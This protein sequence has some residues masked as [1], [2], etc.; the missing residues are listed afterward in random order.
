MSV[1][2]YSC[3]SDQNLKICNYIKP[4]SNAAVRFLENSMLDTSMLDKNNT[5]PVKRGLYKCNYI[6]DSIN[7]EM[8]KRKT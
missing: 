5:V 3:T 7:A 1:K 8:C 2:K 4:S 6:N